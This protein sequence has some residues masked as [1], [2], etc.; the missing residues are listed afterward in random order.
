VVVAP[1]SH[2]QT[3]RFCDAKV[4]CETKG[5]KRAVICGSDG[6]F[7]TSQCDMRKTNCGL[8]TC[9]YAIIYI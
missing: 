7:Y 1:A 5:A 3:T 2:C 4:K 8:V 6:Q 9:V